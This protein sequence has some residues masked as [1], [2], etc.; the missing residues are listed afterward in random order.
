MEDSCPPLFVQGVCKLHNLRIS[1]KVA[2]SSAVYLFD[3]ANI[4]PAYDREYTWL[5]DR[6][7]TAKITVSYFE[8]IGFEYDEIAN[9]AVR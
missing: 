1:S 5:S 6:S 4:Y 9:L 8:Q 3:R 2:P 7:I